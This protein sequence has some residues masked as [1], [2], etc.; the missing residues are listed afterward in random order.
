MNVLITPMIGLGDTILTTPAVHL[1]KKNFP[2][3]KITYFTMGNQ[4]KYILQNNPY[5]DNIISYPLIQ[6]K[7]KSIYQI[8]KN[9]TLQYPINITF[10]PSNRYHYNIFSILTLAKERYGHK[11]IND[12]WW[13]L[14]SL[15]NKTIKE[16]INYHCV[17]ENVELIRLLEP[18]ISNQNIPN[19]EVFLTDQEITS[20]EKLI[21][22]RKINI[23][24]HAGCDIKKNHINRRWPLNNFVELINKLNDN[25]KFF[26]FGNTQEKNINQFIIENTKSDTTLI[27][28]PNI[29]DTAKLINQMN[30][31]ISNDSGLMH[32]ASALNI[33]TIVILGPTN[34][35][36]IKPWKIPHKIISLNLKCSPCFNYSPKPLT[37]SQFNQFECVK[38]ISS[39]LVINN[40]YDL[41]NDIS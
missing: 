7:F 24:I 29:R 36:L 31:F 30:V 33:P 8:L 21:P 9:I 39:D 2:N 15:K 3:Y 5:I 22:K 32:L 37:C 23:G 27:E 12:K 13:Y 40:L 25:F 14:N 16:N 10:Y 17:E 4:Q 11:Y 38:N 1:L 35:T 28:Y 6:N 18:S 20:A 26:I 41:L 34:Q 19:L